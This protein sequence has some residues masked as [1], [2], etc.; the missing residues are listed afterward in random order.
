MTAALVYLAILVVA[1]FF[2]I[3]LPQRRRLSAHRAL[4]DATEVGDEVVT[5]AGLFGTVREITET[6]LR[7]EIAPEVVVTVA[8]GAIS[9]RNVP[10]A[11]AVADVDVGD[12]V[13]QRPAD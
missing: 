6:T 4:V 7:L 3:V 9:Q 13:E 10:A 12:A 2:L 5:T 1:F 8:R 11:P